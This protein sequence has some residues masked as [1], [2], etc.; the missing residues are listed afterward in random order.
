LSRNKIGLDSTYYFLSDP[1]IGDVGATG[2][3]SFTSQWRVSDLNYPGVF[4]G[5][6]GLANFQLFWN[7]I[8][9]HSVDAQFYITNAFDRTYRMFNTTTY[10]SEGAESTVYGEPRIFGVKLRWNWN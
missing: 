4:A 3:Y 6:Y 5:G 8:Y 9:G 2:T 1:G 7:S 10:A